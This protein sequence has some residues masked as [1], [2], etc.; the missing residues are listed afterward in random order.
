LPLAAEEHAGGCE[1]DVARVHAACACCAADD[2][3]TARNEVTA[4]YAVLPPAPCPTRR[5]PTSQPRGAG[6]ARER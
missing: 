4:R 1:R 3:L 2:E 6:I 5:W